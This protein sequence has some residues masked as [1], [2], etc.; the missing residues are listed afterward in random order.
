MFSLATIQRINNVFEVAKARRVA[1]GLNNPGE[2][3]KGVE[4]GQKD[5]H[6][7]DPLK[8]KMAGVD[9]RK[10]RRISSVAH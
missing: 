2:H 3:P 4:K 1:R 6:F 8:T 5:H 7:I 10:L 9:N